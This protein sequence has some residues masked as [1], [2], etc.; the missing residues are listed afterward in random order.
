MQ[1]NLFDEMP[2]REIENTNEMGK[3]EIVTTMKNYY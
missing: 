3:L 2:Q 1:S